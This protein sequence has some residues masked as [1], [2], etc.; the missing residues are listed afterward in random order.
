MTV[1]PA[2][3]KSDYFRAGYEDVIDSFT[4]EN[5]NP[6]PSYTFTFTSA[7]SG[8]PELG[9]GIKSFSADD[10]LGT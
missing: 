8:L 1:P 6:V 9:Y 2:W 10:Y 3:I 7:L 5:T 4:D